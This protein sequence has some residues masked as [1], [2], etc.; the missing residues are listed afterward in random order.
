M[1]LISIIKLIIHSVHP[2]SIFTVIHAFSQWAI[3]QNT[4][5]HLS[6]AFMIMN[7]RLINSIGVLLTQFPRRS[8]SIKAAMHPAVPITYQQGQ[9]GTVEEHTEEKG[10]I[11]KLHLNKDAY[12]LCTFKFSRCH[13]G[14]KRQDKQQL[15]RRKA[16]ADGIKQRALQRVLNIVGHN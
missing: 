9:K 2:N 1:S 7:E 4:N 14:S 15:E 12:I 5:P 13:L 11:L 10:N 16:C 6:T 8:N 3:F